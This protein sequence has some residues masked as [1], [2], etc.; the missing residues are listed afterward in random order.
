MRC[1][2][3]AH[4]YLSELL[5]WCLCQ[6]Y[7]CWPC[8]RQMFLC[9]IYFLHLTDL[10]DNL[11]CVT[12]KILFFLVCIIWRGFI[13][14]FLH[15]DHI[16]T[17][18]THY[19]P[20]ADQ[21]SYPPINAF[22]NVYSKDIHPFITTRVHLGCG[23]MGSNMWLL[24]C[25][26]SPFFFYSWLSMTSEGGDFPNMVICCLLVAANQKKGSLKGMELRQR[27]QYKLNK[28]YFEL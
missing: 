11:S 19:R 1:F 22:T 24:R 4:H 28:D 9:T 23:G 7:R 5:L 25:S 17:H 3:I 2:S 12:W 18:L 15:F 20:I 21:I 26:I 10:S 27:T 16:Y 14:I 13:T 6:Y 8:F